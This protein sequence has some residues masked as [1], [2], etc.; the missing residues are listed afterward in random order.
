MAALPLANLS[1]AGS[2]RLQDSPVSLIVETGLDEEGNFVTMGTSW[3]TRGAKVIVLG[4]LMDGPA[5]EAPVQQ[6]M[7]VIL[8]VGTDLWLTQSYVMISRMTG[9]DV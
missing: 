5:L 4:V 8:H 2:V 3:T 9:M 7:D 6:L 1:L